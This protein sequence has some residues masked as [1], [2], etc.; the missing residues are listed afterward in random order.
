MSTPER[1]LK[2]EMEEFQRKERLRQ[3]MEQ[4][5]AQ[6]KEDTPWY[7]SVE[8]AI[9]D[10]R[11]LNEGAVGS[12]LETHYGLKDLGRKVGLVGEESA[13]ADRAELKKWKDASKRSNWGGAGRIGGEMLQYAVPGGAGV[14]LGRGLA[15]AGKA[16]S[17]VVPLA[18]DVLGTAAI[19][20]AKLPEEGETRGSNALR[21]G[22]A[23]G[24]GA[25][26]AK[27]LSVV[28]GGARGPSE[29]FRTM[30]DK[31]WNP[32]V[33]EAVPILN[34]VE[35]I[36]AY[37][38]FV[39]RAIGKQ[40]ALG[41]LSV[42]ELAIREAPPPSVASIREF[43]DGTGDLVTAQPSAVGHEGVREL[44][45]MFKGAYG[46]V[47]P[48][49]GKI[50]K[51]VWAR[52]AH[53]VLKRAKRALSPK[54]YNDVVRAYK[55]VRHKLN[56]LNTGDSAKIIDDILRENVKGVSKKKTRQLL[57]MKHLRDSWRN[58]IP[59]KNRIALGEIEKAYGKYSAVNN[60][61]GLAS[62]SKRMEDAAL[63][64]GGR[65][66]F[67][68]L[69]PKSNFGWSKRSRQ[70]YMIENPNAGMFDLDELMRG[71]LQAT[72]T[73]GARGRG[74]T[75]MNDFITP[76]LSL[77][78]NR[79]GAL[80]T[81]GVRIS[82]ALPTLGPVFTTGQ[83]VSGNMAYQKAIRDILKKYET[84]ALPYYMS[85]ARAGAAIEDY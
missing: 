84:S 13:D 53:S 54:Q 80:P 43:I 79:V 32:T 24:A 59:E 58:A 11:D 2:K 33:G 77:R 30:R 39:A 31:G 49:V 18:A 45:D 57:M 50:N 74:Q 66:S 81:I 68:R 9:E 56:T 65:G 48:S 38:P 20:A 46:E 67:R 83:M 23:A 5:R 69:S 16:G 6:Q 21:E 7:G 14:Q 42:H 60:A 12:L 25:G 85:A 55:E 1:D 34:R 71:N 62:A 47:F 61:A 26:L 8:G 70:A 35:N 64:G 28:G 37:T 36:G 82:Q 41:E 4:W 72:L 78:G 3:E 63:V 75:P 10:W 27:A 29:L 44:Y 73:K 17:R 22:L 51:G 40:R 19:G 76:M 15:A 52:G